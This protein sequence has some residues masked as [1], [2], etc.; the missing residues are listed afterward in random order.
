MLAMPGHRESRFDAALDNA[1]HAALA[2]LGLRAE[3]MVDTGDN[4]NEEM[5]PIFRNWVDA[6]GEAGIPDEVPTTPIA[7]TIA[8]EITFEDRVSDAARVAVSAFGIDPDR[9]LETTEEIA[10]AIARIL[11]PHLVLDEPDDLDPGR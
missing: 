9:A 10:D 1:T 6:S 11:R 7:K 5:E 2:V 3:N 8:D 4:L